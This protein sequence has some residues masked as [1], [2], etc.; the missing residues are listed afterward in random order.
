M[1]NFPTNTTMLFH[2]S[3]CE[4]A[5]N[6]STYDYNK[7]TWRKIGLHLFLNIQAVSCYDFLYYIA[8]SSMS[9]ALEIRI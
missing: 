9:V 2:R 3:F 7:V 1:L 4:W 8:S 6:L 5:H